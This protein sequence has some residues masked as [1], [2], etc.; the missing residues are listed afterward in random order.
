LLISE[1]IVRNLAVDKKRKTLRSSDRCASRRGS[2]LVDAI[3]GAII[4]GVAI[5]MLVPALTAVRRQRQSIRFESLAMLEL[6][7]I[8]ALLPDTVD[9]ASPPALSEWFHNRYAT[10]QLKFEI[11]P[12]STDE[13]TKIQQP[14]R[15]TIHRPAET[16]LPDQQVSVVIWRQLPEVAP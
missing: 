2:L 10:A 12:P 1:V 8:D 9:Q 7:N 6:N 3:I 11:L 13:A 5:S 16:S 4:M 15:L 14:V